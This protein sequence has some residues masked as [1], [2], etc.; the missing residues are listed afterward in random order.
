MA[1]SE[2]T[3]NNGVVR[4]QFDFNGIPDHNAWGLTPS[5][6]VQVGE[7]SYRLPKYPTLLTEDEG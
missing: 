4:Q 6:T 2:I 5:G 7:L 3:A 1:T